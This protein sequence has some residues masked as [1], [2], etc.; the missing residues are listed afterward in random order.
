MKM[1]PDMESED[2]RGMRE[3]IEE[4][5]QELKGMERDIA[6]AKKILDPEMREV[7]VKNLTKMRD[8]TR[9]MIAS[10]EETYKVMLVSEARLYDLRQEDAGD[11]R[12]VDAG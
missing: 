12:A 10:F 1:K 6:E 5:E 3:S 2:L 11:G 8:S 9:E 7:A 4:M